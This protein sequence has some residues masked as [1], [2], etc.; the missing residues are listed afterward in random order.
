MMTVEERLKM[1][2]EK[3][4]FI[5]NIAAAFVK[6]PKGHSVRDITYEVWHK[7][8]EQFGHIF[9]EWII[10]H[11][12]GGAISPRRVEGNSNTANFRAIGEMLDSSY[13]EDLYL[14]KESQVALGYRKVDLTKL[15]LTEV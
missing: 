15:F 11:Y 13:Y 10:V 2:R 4:Q 1:Y 9:V 12:D 7:E 5:Y 14:Y 3:K 6:C 8:S